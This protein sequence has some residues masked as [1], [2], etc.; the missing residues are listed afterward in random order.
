MICVSVTP[1]SRQLAKVDLLNASRQGDMI[2]LCIDH[3]IK[4]PDFENLIQAI[5]KP[6][7]ISCRRKKDGGEWGGT[8]EDRLHLLRLAIAASPAY[9]ELDLD[10]ASLIPRFGET[11]RV[12]SSI[13]LDRPE[14]DLDAVFDEAANKQAD[15]VK[16]C[17]PTPTLNAAWP[18]LV[19]I[20]QKRILPVVGQG[21]GRAELTF[22]LL[23]Q[24][25]GSP[26]IYA[27]LE[28]GME[29]HPGQATIHE[30][31]EVYHY[32]H[33]N[34]KTKFVGVVG[35]TQRQ[36]EVT[37]ILNIGF[38]LLGLNLRSLPLQFGKLNSLAKKLKKLK[39]QSLILDEETSS[40]IKPFVNQASG[41][42]QNSDAFDFLEYKD[43]QWDGKNIRLPCAITELKAAF[44]KES[45][46]EP[47]K[48]K[49]SLILGAGPIV[50]SLVVELQQQGCLV[51]I[52][53]TDEKA[54]EEIAREH[55]IRFL[56]I[57]DIYNTFSEITILADPNLKFGDQRNEIHPS[58]FR[59]GQVVQ[60]LALEGDR[61]S[62]Y[63]Q[64]RDHHARLLDGAKLFKKQLQ[65]QFHAL[66]GKRL[67][68]KAFG[69]KAAL[70]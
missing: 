3:L 39:I 37:K 10:A 34:Q 29:S 4:V 33:I 25:Y 6:I 24:K 5:D 16:F 62:V 14:F 15:I 58:F 54:A 60:D 40:R 66:T 45:L 59:H 32:S 20:S 50:K 35:F 31:N 52:S 41:Q 12:V 19:A 1:K 64:I 49:N 69:E 2:E 44:Q 23:S 47:L 43:G 63:E 27:A 46:D 36:T 70:P 67:P 61:S 48:N 56:P 55:Q 18:L 17:W 42:D 13:R 26:W 53:S 68:E 7:L 57:G 22:S 30:L 38:Q 51:T 65:L 9:V 8:E 28:K 21:L 11:K